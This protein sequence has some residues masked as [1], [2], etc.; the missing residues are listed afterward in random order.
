MD[1]DSLIA[2]HAWFDRYVRSF[3]SD[4]AG[5]QA[6]IELKEKHTKKVCENMT[7][8]GSHLMLQDNALRLAETIALFHDVGRFEQYRRYRTFSDLKSE[9]HALT[10]IRVL[11]ELDVLS[12]LDRKEKR[13]VLKAVEYHNILYL[14]ADEDDEVLFF[15]KMIR[16][17]DK[18]DAYDIVVNYYEGRDQR[19]N[20]VLEDFPDQ[21][22]CTSAIVDS[23]IKG[24]NINYKDA[25][26]LND[27]K[28]TY[29]AWIFDIN[30][31][32]TLQEVKR[33]GYIDRLFKLLPQEPDIE[34]AYQCVR[35]YIEKRIVETE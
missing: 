32:F 25:K 2:F 15:S 8:L 12:G 33:R 16:D 24:E 31:G 1:R 14:P 3:Y 28:L 9:N 4:D 10:G 26:T 11:E 7:G 13:L 6:N 19:R 5:L 35:D 18:L 29:V 23:I 30:Y 20:Q 21:P 17:A 27:R 22:Y 34:R